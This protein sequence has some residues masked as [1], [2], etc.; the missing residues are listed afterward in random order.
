MEKMLDRV[1]VAKSMRKVLV[2]RL[3]NT[4]CV[5]RKKL[6]FETIYR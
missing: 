5:N 6:C 1:N 4:N 3:G 2:L